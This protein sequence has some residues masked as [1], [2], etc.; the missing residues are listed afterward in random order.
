MKSKFRAEFV[1]NLILSPVRIWYSFRIVASP[2][3]R[4]NTNKNCDIHFKK[5]VVIERLT[6]PQGT[7]CPYE[8]TVRLSTKVLDIEKHFFRKKNKFFQSFREFCEQ[9]KFLKVSDSLHHEY[10]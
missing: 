4:D 5:P 9:Q 7:F 6:P 8:T 2:F 3:C 10:F 1:F